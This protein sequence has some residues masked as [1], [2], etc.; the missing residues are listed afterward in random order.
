MIR[1]VD[2]AD[3]AHKNLVDNGKQ[4][5]NLNWFFT[6][7]GTIYMPHNL[8]LLVFI[9]PEQRGLPWCLATQMMKTTASKLF[10]RRGACWPKPGSF[11]QGPQ[12]PASDVEFKKQK[13]CFFLLA[14]Q[15][16]IHKRSHHFLLERI[17]TFFWSIDVNFFRRISEKWEFILKHLS[18]PLQG[19]FPSI[20]VCF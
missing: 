18:W 3:P 10:A 5:I 19:F 16:K 2:E 17:S 8:S 9:S 6:I 15:Q 20:L 1:I 11:P 7:N 4:I 12:Q 13:G 14:T